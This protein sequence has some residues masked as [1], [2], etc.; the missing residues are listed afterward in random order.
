MLTPEQ[1]AVAIREAWCQGDLRYK[2]KPVQRRILKNIE[3]NT[4]LTY[5]VNC[6]RRGGK[7]TT[8]AALAIQT[9]IKIPKC[10]I[11]YGAPSKEDLKDF[12]LPIF[13]EIFLDCPQDLRPEWKTSLNRWIFS[14]GSSIKLCGC[15]D[16]NYQNLRGKKSDLFILDEAAQIDDLD[17]IVKS[18]ALPLLLSSTNKHKKIILPS[19]PPDSPGHAFKKYAESAKALGAYSEYTID[20][21][22]YSP[23][24]IERFIK[25]SGGRESTAVQ[26]EYFCKFVTEGSLQIIPEWK[27]DLF[28]LEQ[29]KDDY[30]KFY[31]PVEAL[32]IGYRDF[33]AWFVG[34][35]DFNAAKLVIEHEIALRE[36]SFTTEALA[37]EIKKIEESFLKDSQARI[38]RVADNNNL[39]ILADLSKIYRLPFSP[40]SKKNGKEWMVNQARQF[41]KA[42][43][44]VINPRCKMLITSLEFGIWKRNRDDFERS[45]DLGH[46]DFVDALVYLISGL[47][48]II[49]NVNPIPP[50][51]QL[52]LHKTMF[53]NNQIPKQ[54]MS[55]TDEAIKNLFKLR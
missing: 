31:I 11:Q 47:V 17:I 42:G 3:D 48:P 50:L 49:Q 52:D 29:P 1:R 35:W 51:Y 46:Y 33:T 22:W 2:L 9:A 10:Q 27:S 37:S 39:N 45:A 28:V 36:N 53:P 38:R 15:N 25:E 8:M 5:V 13:E 23:E 43:K 12:I 26:R 34:Y 24:E 14:N 40:V 41:I 21:T 32:D 4:E 16:K 19:T 20:E 7:S 55:Q 6:T 18:I 44:L 30:F 54:S